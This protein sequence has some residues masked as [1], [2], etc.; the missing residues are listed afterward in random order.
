MVRS[1]VQ[2]VISRVL[3]N[4]IDLFD[5][6]GQQCPGF[7]DNIRLLTA[8]MRAA[9]SWDRAKAAWMIAAF[10]DSQ[11]SRVPRREPKTRGGKIRDVGRPFMHLHERTRTTQS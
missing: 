9:H 8:A 3:R 1:Q 4:Q 11:I 5:A 6:I 2:S 7:G 10:R